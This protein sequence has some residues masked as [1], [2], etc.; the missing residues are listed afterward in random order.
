[1]VIVPN[2]V[3]EDVLGTANS[4]V[5]TI[6]NGASLLGPLFG[7]VLISNFGATV[8]IFID[9][10]SFWCAA[11]CVFFVK[12]TQ[13]F[14][15]TS[16]SKERP[17]CRFFKEVWEGLKLLFQLK[18]VWWI[19]LGALFFNLA[20][21]QLEVSL[22]LFT[23]KELKSNAFIL[24]TFWTIY[25]IGSLIGAFVS[26]FLSKENK[27]G[28]Y[29]GLMAIGWGMSFIP[30]IWWHSL[31]IMYVSMILSGLLFGG[32][33]PLARTTVQRL[34]PKAFQGRIFGIR[35]SI[36]ALGMPIGSYLSGTLGQWMLPSSVIGLMGVVVI[37]MG[38]LL[39]SMRSFR[40]LSN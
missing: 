8:A 10:L 40:E 15:E 37:F 17:S 14:I 34:V 39:I 33:P 2:V 11:L 5:E 32:Y 30:I 20:Y 36:I 19:T 25:F 9:G 18:A 7:G 28:I 29:M 6:W 1:M 16:T 4:I 21:G 38:L 35:G 23:H 27:S 13:T 12:E 26:G 31:L 24:G 3:S 22:P